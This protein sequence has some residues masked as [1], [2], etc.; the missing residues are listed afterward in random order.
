MVLES[1]PRTKKWMVRADAGEVDE[2]AG[3]EEEE[4][5]SAPRAAVKADDEA[6][7]ESGWA[8]SGSLEEG[9]A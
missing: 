9:S 3:D 8:I 4:A 7:L 2:K 1:V 5:P 6:V